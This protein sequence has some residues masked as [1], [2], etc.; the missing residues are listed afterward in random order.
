MHNNS[1]FDGTS[2]QLFGWIFVGL[3]VTICS[4][5]LFFPWMI[6]RLY[7]WEVNHTVV[8]G[9]RLRFTGDIYGSLGDWV[10]WYVLVF[11]TGGLYLLRLIVLF[12][13]WK[14]KHTRFLY[15]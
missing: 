6:F 12:K 8:N 5:G 13:R 2:L 3:L 10:I 1:E 4:L 15:S 11:I 7:E 14:A 9:R